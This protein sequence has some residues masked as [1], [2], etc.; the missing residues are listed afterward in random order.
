[1]NN[2]KYEILLAELADLIKSKN[3]KIE[4]QDYTIK[5]LSKKINDIEKTV[6]ESGK[7][8]NIERR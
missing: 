3:E 8:Q 7:P 1:M 6:Q 4:L 2:E 5:V